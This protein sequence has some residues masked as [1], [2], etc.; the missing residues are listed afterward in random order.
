[1][2]AADEPEVVVDAHAG[3][4]EGRVWDAARGML[5]WLDIPG[6][7]IH[8]YDPDTGADT[9]FT[10]PMPVGSVALRDRGGLVLAMLDGS[11]CASRISR[12]CGGS[13]R[14][15]RTGRTTR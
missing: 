11:G 2:L 8:E 3:V 1:M 9:T 10:V 5:F 13:C 6:R 14:S 15:K 7:L 4:G 12:I